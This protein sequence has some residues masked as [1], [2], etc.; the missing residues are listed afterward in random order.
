M[1]VGPCSRTRTTRRPAESIP[2]TRD[3]D[4]GT[5]CNADRVRTVRAERDRGQP[6]TRRESSS[7]PPDA[8]PRN[9]HLESSAPGRGRGHHAGEE[10]GPWRRKASAGNADLDRLR[11]DVRA[12]AAG[13]STSA[14][15]IT[16][17]PLV[18][19]PCQSTTSPPPRLGV[20]VTMPCGQLVF[21]RRL[22][23]TVAWPAASTVSVRPRRVGRWSRR[24][25]DMSAQLPWSPRRNSP[26]SVVQNP[27]L[28]E[29]TFR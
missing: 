26:T 11:D 4:G 3:R 28:A 1:P 24:A 22:A 17:T 6:S 27:R 20:T 13:C 18:V 29:P 5:T 2:S 8:G 9:P 14:A 19:L 16:E 25:V 12:P 23:G 15:L 10:A 21:C 7:R